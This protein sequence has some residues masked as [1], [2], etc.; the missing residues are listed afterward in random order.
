[1][2]G[3]CST[4]ISCTQVTVSTTVENCTACAAPYPTLVVGGCTNVTYCTN[5][6][7]DLSSSV[8]IQCMT[9]LVS[10]SINSTNDTCACPITKF[11]QTV[12]PLTCGNCPYQCD[13]CNSTS[14][15]MTCSAGIPV[16]G[17]CSTKI[18]CTKVTVSTTNETC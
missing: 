12:S 6:S 11:I 3:G 10:F 1:M 18:S 9:P 14:S 2:T 7:S 8:C 15:C 4:K 13:A 17:G 16:T 5:V